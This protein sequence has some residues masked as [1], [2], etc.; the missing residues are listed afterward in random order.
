MRTFRLSVQPS[1]CRPV[2]NAAMRARPSGSS[3][4]SPLSTAILR[5]SCA[6]AASGHASAPASAARKLR[7]L[8]PRSRLERITGERGGARVRRPIRQTFD[9]CCALAGH[10]I[11]ASPGRPMSSRHLMLP[12]Q[13]Q[14]GPHRNRKQ[15][16]AEGGTD[17]F[18]QRLLCAAGPADDGEGQPPK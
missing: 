11:A 14:E 13:A 12:P 5:G 18:R 15:Y 16:F 8:M 9:S 7:R 4:G 10:T 17:G 6:R 2:R 1:L 3:S